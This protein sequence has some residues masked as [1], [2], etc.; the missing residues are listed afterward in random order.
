MPTSLSLTKDSSGT[1]R[2]WED[3][4]RDARSGCRDAQARLLQELRPYLV[5][6]AA[7]ELDTRLRVKVDQSDLVQDVLLQAWKGLPGFRGGTRAELIAWLQT[8]LKNRSIDVVRQYRSSEKRSDRREEAIKP[9][10]ATERS[11]EAVDDSPSHQAMGR[12]QRE[13][14]ERA[15]RCLLPADEQVLRLRGQ[16]ELSFSE[17]GRILEVSEDAARKRFARAAEKLGRELE[18]NGG[19]Q[20]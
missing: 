6:R 12:E 4:V 14:V 19:R 3:C 9:N 15:M 20:D 10:Q 11:L 2:A 18:R 8:L 13:L 1:Q 7:S 5:R 16:T 17:I